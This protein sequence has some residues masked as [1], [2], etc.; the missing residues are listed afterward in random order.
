MPPWTGL[1]NNLKEVFTEVLV[2]LQRY[3]KDMPKNTLLHF[4]FKAITRHYQHFYELCT[5]PGKMTDVSSIK[6][7]SKKVESFEG[8]WSNLSIL[9]KSIPFDDKVCD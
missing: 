7:M 4:I 5:L 1:L 8:Y 9:E 3:P 6:K 2:H